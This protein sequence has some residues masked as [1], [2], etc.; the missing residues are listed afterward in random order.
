MKKELSIKEYAKSINDKPL[1]VRQR[2][3]TIEGWKKQLQDLE[4]EAFNCQNLDH[5]IK[6]TKLKFKIKNAIQ[7]YREDGHI[8]VLVD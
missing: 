5:E 7:Y 1:N 3:R 6:M 4:T 8:F 2:I